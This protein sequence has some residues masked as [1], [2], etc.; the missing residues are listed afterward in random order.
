MCALSNMF[1]IMS[2]LQKESELQA[3][4]TKE[5]PKVQNT[6]VQYI[7]IFYIFS[8]RWNREMTEAKVSRSFKKTL[9]FLVE[10]IQQPPPCTQ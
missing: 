10:A 7:T 5:D 3:K 4:N 8:S 1:M 9:N 2:V 6:S